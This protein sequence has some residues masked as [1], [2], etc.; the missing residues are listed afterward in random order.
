[1]P[2]SS[3][4]A[5]ALASL[6][7]A[8][9]VLHACQDSQVPTEAERAVSATVLK[10]LIVTAS[11]TGN[12]TVTSSPAGIACTVTAGQ[13]AATGCT[14]P[15]SQ[16]VI[17]T[18][19]AKPA[20]GHAFRGWWSGGCSGTG[21]CKTTMSVARTIE[22]RFLKGPFN[23]KIAG[24]GTGSGRI[25]TQTGLTPALDCV[26]TKGVAAATGCLASYPAYTVLT[27]TATAAAG[28]SFTGWSAPC[29]GTGTCT[30][31]AIQTRTFTAAF[32]AGVSSTAA[33]QGK[34]GA[35]IATPIVAIHMNLLRTGKVLLWGDSLA[36]QLWDPANQGAGFT[37][38]T[39][40]HR[41]FCSG[42]TFLSDGRLLVTGGRIDGT[43]GEPY[44]SLF[45]PSTGS[46][47]ATPAMAQ[48][49]YYPT[50]TA[51][52]HGGA[53]VISGNNETKQVVTIPE[54][55]SGS[56]WRRLTTA[57]LAI[58]APFY[59]DMFVAP[60]GKIFLAG[61]LATSSYLDVSGTGA[62]TTVA[63]RRVADRTMGS[64]V[65]Y[66]PG[67]ILYVGG[68]DPPTGSAE[69]IDLNQAA[70]AWR[71]VPGMHFA[72][73]QMNATILAD[74]K[75]LATHGTSGP[76]F[77]DITNPVLDA[78]LW[79]PATETWTLMAREAAGRTYHSTALLLPDGR[80]L[81]SGSGEG[82]GV[83][84]ANSQRTAQIYSPPYLF[85]PD[86]TAAHRP[87]I[88]SAPASLGYGQTIAVGS[89]DAATVHRG[90]LIRLSSVTHAFNQSQLL[91]PLTFTA[92]GAT[93]LQADGPPTAN[94]APA[95]PY[96]LFLI[97]DAG[98]PSQA[99]MI[100]IGP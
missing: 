35:P 25:K 87:P 27:L 73:R 49:R 23:V 37:A 63:T 76:G 11:G 28:S 53:L 51:L 2:R 45:D 32:G 42:H 26:I 67:K 48:G 30:Y 90:T 41:I 1:M 18:L 19:T 98:V 16:G 79:N 46:W 88:A 89:A 50:V 99:R 59:P 94:V 84:F 83:K 66:T 78:E 93:T 92:T 72:R 34:W 14:A 81:S 5:V 55:W 85:N 96:M 31:T 61:F 65:M 75:V 3:R 58:G 33:T 17:V 56:S 100:T 29:S 62:W 69:V 43:A 12:G 54:I 82:G 6:A 39:K 36:A 13:A 95:G 70:P 7:I 68:G 24:T 64:A 9:A 38:V 8:L 15:F 91:Y 74:G 21:S 44:A 60:N 47:T 40:S 97:N 4:T 52:P 86:G 77:N 10:T 80:V 20:A 57:P 71:T 22:A